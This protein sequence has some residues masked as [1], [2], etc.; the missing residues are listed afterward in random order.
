[1]IKK[2]K[3]QKDYKLISNQRKALQLEVT[4]YLDNDIA[5]IPKKKLNGGRQTKSIA[6]RLKGKSN[7]FF[8]KSDTKNMN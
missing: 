6:A 5:S 3:N 2:N 4:T 1:M 7:R 8:R